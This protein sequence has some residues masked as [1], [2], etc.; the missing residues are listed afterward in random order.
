[1]LDRR[2]LR[3]VKL[4]ML[5]FTS[6]CDP[7]LNAVIVQAYSVLLLATDWMAWLQIPLRTWDLS[8]HHCVCRLND[9]EAHPGS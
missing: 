8:F 3:P 9:S 2:M 1:M 6:K 7:I 4:V 5:Y